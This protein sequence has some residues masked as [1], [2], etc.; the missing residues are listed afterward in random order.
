MRET[1][2]RQKSKRRVKGEKQDQVIDRILGDIQEIYKRETEERL[3]RD[4]REIGENRREIDRRETGERQERDR[5]EPGEE[6]DRNMRFSD[7]KNSF[8]F[9]SIDRRRETGES[10]ERNMVET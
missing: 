4:R 6:H 10:Q 1:G 2:N 7:I 9:L 5:R 8:L 3:G